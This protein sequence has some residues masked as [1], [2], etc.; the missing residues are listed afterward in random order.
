MRICLNKDDLKY[1]FKALKPALSKDGARPMLSL[2][3]LQCQDGICTAYATDSHRLHSVTVPYSGDN[4]TMLIPV[5]DIPK[6]GDTFL[7]IT[8]DGMNI[9]LNF[10]SETRTVPTTKG[11]FP[12][13][14]EVLPKKDPVFQI[15]FNPKYIKDACDAFSKSN[16]IIFN[17]MG[18]QHE[19]CVI[20][21]DKGKYAEGEDFALVLPIRLN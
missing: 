20:K 10:G 17:F 12:K 4:G 8:D 11:A 13:V 6:G 9:S 1:I 21:A 16:C 3:Q 19:A 2:I 5:V 18:N 7:E 15:A 14:E